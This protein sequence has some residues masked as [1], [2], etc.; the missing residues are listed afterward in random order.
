MLAGQDGRANAARPA[1][2]LPRTARTVRPPPSSALAGRDIVMVES[3]CDRGEAGALC[4]LVANPLDDLRRERGLSTTWRCASTRCP[5]LLGTL[6]N[7]RNEKVP[8][9]GDF[10][11][12]SDG[13]RTRDL[14]RDRPRKGRHDHPLL[15]RTSPI[16]RDFCEASTLEATGWHVLARKSRPVLAPPVHRRL[17]QQF[18]E[19]SMGSDPGD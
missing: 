16:S 9:S 19:A 18:G 11:N 8:A 7:A 14:R 12:G 2:E 15:T 5:R 1:R 4:V 6:G 10:R 3:A 17:R 13:T